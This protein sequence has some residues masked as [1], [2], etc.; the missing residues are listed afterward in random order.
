MASSCRHEIG[1][2]GI[3]ALCQPRMPWHLGQL[4]VISN[5]RLSYYLW[6]GENILHI[7]RFCGETPDDRTF[8]SALK[9]MMRI[10]RKGTF[11]PGSNR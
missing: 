1:D 9:P 3:N 4:L 7:H 10:G 11:S 5:N 2:S 6:V 8:R